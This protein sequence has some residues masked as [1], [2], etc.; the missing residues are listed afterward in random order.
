MQTRH[1]LIATIAVCGALATAAS[2]AQTPPATP[3]LPPASPALPTTPST[4]RT[5][6]QQA[7]LQRQQQQLH[8]GVQ[9]TTDQ[10]MH[11]PAAQTPTGMQSPTNPAA[12]SSSH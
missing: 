3:T 1:S 6:P 12:A 5:T 2:F 4:T 7:E 9:S 11:P 8:N 10:G